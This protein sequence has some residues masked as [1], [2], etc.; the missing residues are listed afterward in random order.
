M[1]DVRTMEERDVLQGEGREGAARLPLLLSRSATRSELEARIRC[2]SLFSLPSPRLWPFALHNSPRIHNPELDG[3]GT[4]K[5]NE[6]EY[7]PAKTILH[8]PPL[9]HTKFRSCTHSCCI[10]KYTQHS[11]LVSPSPASP[12]SSFS[13]PHL[14]SF[15]PVPQTFC[16]RP[17]SRLAQCVRLQLEH[18]V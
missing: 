3:E 9:A 17:T 11:V 5:K 2:E 7:I 14:T 10:C 6:K 18:E 8:P 13:F 1:C 15:S 16:K 4:E 12:S